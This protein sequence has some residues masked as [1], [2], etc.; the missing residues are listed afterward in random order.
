MRSNS[1]KHSQ[2]AIQGQLLRPQSESERVL[3][4]LV[5]M[6]TRI[7]KPF[8]EARMQQ[9]HDDLAN[10][11]VEAI[12]WALDSWA[13]NAKVLPALADLL[14]LVRTWHIEQEPEKC[15]CRHLHG[16]GYG[17]NDI[18]WLWKKR[19]SSAKPWTEADYETAMQELDKQRAG[20]A[21]VFRR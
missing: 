20:G 19:Q 8:S 14:Q 5:T 17:K 9:L 2:S 13:R 15:E 12:E 1:R 4:A 16:R 6:A 7:G 10:Y 3:Q 18:L 21:P 11:P